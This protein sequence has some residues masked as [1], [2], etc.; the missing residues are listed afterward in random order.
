MVEIIC[1]MIRWTSSNVG[2]GKLSVHVLNKC[3]LNNF[4]KK[5][6]YRVGTMHPRSR[7]FVY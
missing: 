3:L 2:Q 5:L 7:I 4:V 1:E 6:Q